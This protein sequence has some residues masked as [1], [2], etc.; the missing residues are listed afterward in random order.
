MKNIEEKFFCIFKYMGIPK[1]Q[2]RMDASFL[3]DFEFEEFQFGYLVFYLESYFR[4][5]ISENEYP[6]LDTIGSSMDFVKRKLRKRDR[7]KIMRRKNRPVKTLKSIPLNFHH[8]GHR[9]LVYQHLFYWPIL[10]LEV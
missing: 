3:K 6:E 4:I 9:N 5:T 10:S 2:I 1:E 8:R 7:L